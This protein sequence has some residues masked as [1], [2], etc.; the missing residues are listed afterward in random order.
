M[1]KPELPN[2]HPDPATWWA[3][4]RYQAYIALAGVVSLGG[5][6]VAGVVPEGSGPIVQ[7][8]IWALTA[9]VAVYSGGATVVDAMSKVRR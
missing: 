6:A 1:G 8:A 2:E 4:R 7:S 9:I 5:V 3:H